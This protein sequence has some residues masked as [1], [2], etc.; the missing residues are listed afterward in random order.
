MLQYVQTQFT[1]PGISVQW[2]TLTYPQGEVASIGFQ[3]QDYAQELFANQ[4]FVRN[5][6]TA[7][8][9]VHNSSLTDTTWWAWLVI[10]AAEGADL[11]EIRSQ[12]QV[13]VQEEAVQEKA[14]ESA[15]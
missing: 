8:I 13:Q 4:M 3:S 6:T 14:V 7:F 12:L 5:A 10:D 11:S 1:C 9:Q 15:R 2:A